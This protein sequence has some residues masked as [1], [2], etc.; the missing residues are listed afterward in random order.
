MDEPK[1]KEHFMKLTDKTK[2]PV[3]R[4]GKALL[5][6]LLPLVCCIVHCALQ[7]RSLFEVYLPASEWNDELFYFK[8]VEAILENGYPYGYY[9]FNESRAAYLSFAAWSPVLVIPWVLW[10]ALFGWTMLSPVLCNIFLMSLDMFLFVYFTKPGYK[11]MG[12][13]SVLYCLF[14]MFTRYMMSGMPEIICISLVLVF[15]G[16]A[17]SYLQEKASNGKLVCLFVMSVLMTLM[18]PY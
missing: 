12:C 6:A 3:E 10:G 17:I 1:G 9:G 8:Q 2:W 14:P 4:I 18:R 16:V 7:G 15:Y 11:Q 5:M 13:I